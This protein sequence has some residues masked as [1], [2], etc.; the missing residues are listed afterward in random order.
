[1][2]EPKEWVTAKEAAALIGRDVRQIYRWIDAGRLATRINADGVIMVLSK[3][4]LRIEP[5]VKRGRPKGS[6]TRR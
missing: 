3:T 2:A 5:D 1:M 4:V 6:P